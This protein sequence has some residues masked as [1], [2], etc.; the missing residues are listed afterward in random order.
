MRAKARVAGRAA[1]VITVLLAAA[2]I[3]FDV[4]RVVLWQRGLQ[5]RVDTAA[6]VGAAAVAAGHDPD[7]AIRASGA[8]GGDRYQGTPVIA[9]PP[10][11]GAYRNR[12]DAVQVSAAIARRPLLATVMSRDITLRATGTAAFVVFDRERNYGR[13]QRVE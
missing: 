13:V 10:R 8:L 9:H 5:I 2:V 1:V 12:L 4:A 11:H 3:F 6:T 7:R